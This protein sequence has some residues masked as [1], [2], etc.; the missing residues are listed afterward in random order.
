MAASL[1]LLTSANA[2]SASHASSSSRDV[3]AC[4]ELLDRAVAK[5]G[6]RLDRAQ[7]LL[8]RGAAREA[9]TVELGDGP[10]DRRNLGRLERAQH[11][12]RRVEQ[13]DEQRLGHGRP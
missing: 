8:A 10:Q 1:A 9:A 5:F 7:Q 4:K 6:L 11:L 13:R 12:A 2:S 3:G